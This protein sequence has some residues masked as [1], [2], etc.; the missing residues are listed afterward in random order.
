MDDLQ[1]IINVTKVDLGAQ[2]KNGRT[3]LNK[4]VCGFGI[5]IKPEKR[6]VVFID[7]I[8]LRIRFGL[9]LNFYHIWRIGY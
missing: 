7:T 9:N 3:G 4:Y 8:Y 6:I 1:G 2:I 5:K